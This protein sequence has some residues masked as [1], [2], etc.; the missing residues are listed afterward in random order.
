MAT[1]LP[2]QLLVTHSRGR[3][4]VTSGLSPFW[5]CVGGNRRCSVVVRCKLRLY[6]VPVKNKTQYIVPLLR[7][8]P[9]KSLSGCTQ[10]ISGWLVSSILLMDALHFHRRLKDLS[11]PR[12]KVGAAAG[13]GEHPALHLTFDERTFVFR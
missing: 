7:R 11:D 4:E 5:R 9:R 12:G 1:A 13:A 3:L 10:R 8:C 6:M 2:P